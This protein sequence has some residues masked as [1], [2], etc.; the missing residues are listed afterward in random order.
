[1]EEETLCWILTSMILVHSKTLL[2]MHVKL[3]LLKKGDRLFRSEQASPAS[4]TTVMMKHTSNMMSHRTAL[5]E[6]R[7]QRRPRE[8]KYCSSFEMRES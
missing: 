7:W 4:G 5:H 3:S 1:M 8:A 2:K 6:A